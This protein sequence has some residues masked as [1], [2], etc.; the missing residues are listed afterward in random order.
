MIKRISRRDMLRYVGLGGSAALLAA[1]QPK[2]VEV[3]K[4][5]EKSVEKVVTAVVKETV[6]VAGT[7]Q[8]VEKVVEKVVTSTPPPPKASTGPVQ[9]RLS[10]WPSL[11]D[12][13]AY[14]KIVAQFHKDQKAIEVTAEQYPGSMY[15]KIMANFAAGNSADVI[16][17]QGVAWHPYVDD[18]L[19]LALDEF[20]SRDN[21]GK[22]WPDLPGYNA[23]CKW[24]GKTYLSPSDTGSVITY[25]NK[26][27]FDKRGVPYPKDGWTWDEFKAILPKLSFKEGA[28]DYFA[29]HDS[30]NGWWWNWGHIMRHDGDLEWDR[31]VEPTK[32][33][34]NEPKMVEKVQWIVDSI[35]QRHIPSPVE[36]GII[37]TA[38][39]GLSFWQGRIAM[40]WSGPWSLSRAWG[41]NA[42]KAGG[43]NYDVVLNPVGKSG[44]NECCPSVNGHFIV[45]QTKAPSES[46][47][48]MKFIMG[49]FAQKAVSDSGRQPGNREIAESYW[50]TAAAKQYNCANVAAFNKAML[51]GQVQVVGGTGLSQN[52]I[53]TQVNPAVD[54]IQAMEPAKVVLDELNPKLQKVLDDYWKGRKA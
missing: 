11:W 35:K 17:V 26:D 9:L 41:P 33:L 10:V 37:S 31:T 28:N 2:V 3:T 43:L 8:V 14:N 54:K 48:L 22:L 44:M 27:L 32:A 6:M 40:A 15:E 19:L 30:Q 34:W 20:I 29:F 1:C 49:E 39:A 4:I 51:Q 47:T 38:G 25:Y 16:Y 46:W 12:M 5:V 42:L 23:Q 50:A 36:F 53:T 24:H 52:Q 21:M 18:G 13:D 45:K 7:P